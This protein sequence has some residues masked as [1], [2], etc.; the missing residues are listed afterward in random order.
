MNKNQKNATKFSRGNCET[1]IKTLGTAQIVLEYASYFLSGLNANPLV[2]NDQK[3]A[4][5]TK[6][7]AIKKD[8]ESIT[9][10]CVVA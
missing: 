7:E 10:K 6:L 9:M 3:K 2:K 1:L 5:R 4:V 8:A